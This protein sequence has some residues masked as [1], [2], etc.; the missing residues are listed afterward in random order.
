VVLRGGNDHVETAIGFT[1]SHFN[2]VWRVP[3]GEEEA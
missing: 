3:A 1:Q 2:I